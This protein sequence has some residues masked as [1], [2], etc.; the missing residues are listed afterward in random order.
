M[1]TAIKFNLFKKRKKNSSPRFW[2]V[3]FLRGVC[4]LL[5]VADHFFVT[6]SFFLPQIWGMFG[7]EFWAG[8][9]ET[10]IW[11]S[12]WPLKHSVRAIVIVLFCV[13]CGISCTLSK[14]NLKRGLVAAFVA[15]MITLI[16]FLGE[17]ILD[18]DMAIYF[19]V[20]HMYAAAI[21]IYCALDALSLLI[22]GSEY[23]Q[24]K[25]KEF[26]ANLFRGILRRGKIKI[27]ADE[28]CENTKVEIDKDGIRVEVRDEED[29]INVRIN[30][31]GIHVKAK[32]EEDDIEVNIGTDGIYI[33]ATDS[34]DEF[35]FG[36]PECM[37][38]ATYFNPVVMTRIWLA[39]LFPAVVGLIF[40]IVYFNFWGQFNVGQAGGGDII[41]TVDRTFEEGHMLNFMSMLLYL[42]QSGGLRVGTDYFPILPWAAFVLLGSAM[43]HIFYKS[44][45]RVWLGKTI[46]GVFG[47][48]VKKIFGGIRTG[49][50]W[51][52][53]L[54]GRKTLWIYVTHQL[55]F[56]GFFALVGL[57]LR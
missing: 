32:D 21:L 19:G 9:R 33:K 2:E 3:D 5:M 11:W 37:D 42:R 54:A 30:A 20:I 12:S 57:I 35:V 1:E 56:F 27:D 26:F 52:I 28:K 48:K 43:G 39:K 14:S 6:A 45:A 41:S 22:G 55:L 23:R 13:L 31:D 16:T 47:A 18:V 15:G 10:A 29:D 38:T 50:H 46:A 49:L 24:L 25:R 34:G 36:K 51:S 17:R 4:I 40:V 8:I 53:G 7:V 44:G